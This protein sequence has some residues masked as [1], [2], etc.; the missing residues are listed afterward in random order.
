VSELPLIYFF[1]D[2]ACY[3]NPGPGGY[4]AIM[5]YD[6][7]GERIE[8]EYVEAFE[9]TTNNRMELMA[10]L[11]ALEVL[12]DSCH[13]VIYSDSGYVVNSINKRWVDT[14]Q[15]QYKKTGETDKKNWDLWQRY[16]ELRVGHR[17]EMRWLRGHKDLTKIKNT[18]TRFLHEMNHRADEACVK[19]RKEGPWTEDLKPENS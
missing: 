10:V 13:V 1:T 5:L 19:A 8:Y 16:L 15:T 6:S 7:G 18:K 3:P 4:A 14:W 2:G 17:I 12:T 9:R 11:K